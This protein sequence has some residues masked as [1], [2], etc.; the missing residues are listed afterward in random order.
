MS[1]MNN[2]AVLNTRTMPPLADLPGCEVMYKGL[3]DLDGMLCIVTKVTS[4]NIGPVIS[5]KSVTKGL[6][7][8]WTRPSDFLTTWDNDLSSA[9]AAWAEPT[10]RR[11]RQAKQPA[12]STQ[13]TPPK[14]STKTP[15][16]IGVAET[17]APAPPSGHVLALTVGGGLCLA[18][19]L[20]IST[21]HAN[22]KV[23]KGPLVYLRV[24]INDLEQ[25][26]AALTSDLNSAVQMG[27]QMALT[28]KSVSARAWVIEHY[29]PSDT[30]ET[31]SLPGF[32][33]SDLP[34]FCRIF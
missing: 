4:D 32:D 1:T 3:H 12:K 21:A 30:Y 2:V 23:E 15:L 16:K 33:A 22:G 17:S 27:Y 25:S 28:E 6:F 20:D 9:A 14:I 29:P 18:S 34:A 26:L 5:L 10:T 13:K 11:R 8:G 31:H 24:V 7:S 19:S